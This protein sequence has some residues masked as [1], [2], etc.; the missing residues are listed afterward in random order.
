M[1]AAFTVRVSDETADKLNQIAEKLDRSRAYMAAEAIEA[2][3]EQQ[4]WQLAEIEAGLA[5]ANRGEFA[6][7]DDVAKVVGKYVKSARQS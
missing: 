7:D 3:V 2:F 4:E 5:E 6:S 1:T